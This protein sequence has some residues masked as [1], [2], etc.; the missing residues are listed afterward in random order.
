MKRCCV[1]GCSNTYSSGV[2][3]HKFPKNE[4]LRRKWIAEVQRTR[5]A[6]KNKN[7]IPGPGT[8]VCSQHFEE[9]C[10]DPC[11]K[12]RE[13]VCGWR[14]RKRLLDD[15]VPTLMKAKDGAKTK[16]TPEKIRG[17]YAKRNRARV[18]Q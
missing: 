18:S 14:S 9:C 3:L 11:V 12:L 2:S 17:A 15:A 10:F 16:A 4:E 8:Y 13:E 6:G 5:V 7:W 1:G